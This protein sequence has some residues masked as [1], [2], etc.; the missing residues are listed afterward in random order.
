MKNVRAAIQTA[1]VLFLIAGLLTPAT[2]WAQDE[3]SENARAQIGALLQ[4]KATWNATE[5]KMDSR[6]ILESKRRL[7]KSF[8]LGF[9]Q[10]RSRARVDDFDRALI[11]IDAT[12]TQD[13]LN[14]ITQLGGE[15][16][17]SVPRFD[18]IRAAVPFEFL[19]TLASHTDIQSIR[20][21]AQA[22]TNK[23]NTTEGDGAHRA[24]IARMNFG[25]DGTGVNIGV[26][27]DSVDDLLRL[28]G[29]GD[30]PPNV[31][32]LPGQA[33]P[34]GNTS[35]GTAM[36]E[37]IFDL[38]PGAN[39]FFATAFN[40]Q[41]SFADNIER[42]QAAGCQVIVDDVGYFAESV[43]QDDDVAQA[44]D[45]V[46]AAGSSYFSAIGN[47]GNFNDGQGGVYEN[48]FIGIPVDLDGVAVIA[49]VFGV[50][51]VT[52]PLTAGAPSVITLQWADPQGGSSNDYD[53]VLVD[54]GGNSVVDFSLNLQNGSQDPFEIIGGA[55]TGFQL[56][57]IRF[58]GADEDRYFHLN[59]NRGRLLN[60]TPG[61][62]SGHA[63]A[64]GA[65]G[66]AA[67]DVASAPGGAGNPFDG[68]EPV[69]TFSSDGPRRIFFDA[70][71]TPLT[72]GNFSSTGGVVRQ[73]PDFAAADGV[74][75]AT[76]VFFPFNP[77]FGTSAAAPHAA[78]LAALLIDAGVFTTP[79]QVRTAFE[80][81]A[82]DIEAPG[83]DRDSGHGIIDINAAL[84]IA[85]DIVLGP[86]SLAVTADGVVGGVLS[87]STEE[88]CPWSAV[89]N[90]PFISI[91]SASL[92]TGNG[93][94]SYTVAPNNGVGRTG[95]ISVGTEIF[96]V[97][98]QA[99]AIP[100]SVVDPVSQAGCIGGSVIFTA[101]GSG[102]GP[103]GQQWQVNEGQ[104]FKNIDGGTGSSLM[105][106]NINQA[107]DGFQYHAVFFNQC[108]NMATVPAVL[109]VGQP[110]TPGSVS[111][112][113][114]TFADRV[115]VQWSAVPGAISYRVF[116]SEASGGGAPVDISGSIA[117]LQFDD[118]TA[119]T[120]TTTGC[121]PREVGIAYRYFIIATNPCGDGPASTTATGAVAD[122]TKISASLRPSNIGDFALM[123]LTLAGIYAF[124]RRRKVVARIAA[125]R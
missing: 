44:V 42:L 53:L 12:V 69:E 46:T 91:T 99:C 24:D 118:L 68:S 101:L 74:M 9:P 71:G 65:F 105:V 16:I 104:G 100:D 3:L 30:L 80:N 109:T 31:T 58:S 79:D 117:T 98:Q 34:P 27:S 48:D 88:S 64:V 5:Q 35:E 83:V 108:G 77:F 22:F 8:V 93:A 110:G 97:N 25:V 2:A 73:K 41:A 115:R 92:G 11:D 19:E 123:L 102:T 15:V 75:T 87:I 54:P 21:A 125:N 14:A 6:L 107:M 85:C 94:I 72:P 103:L 106:N 49:H 121:S 39:L 55:P 28:Q 47:S 29:L 57:V 112:S 60:S 38:A 119:T 82:I 78:A 40:G 32:V 95:T 4:E 51:R 36:L 26:L 90:S 20:Q 67:V 50:N 56:A 122:P 66:I 124:Q 43:F 81:T 111:A 17:V 10:P 113:N 70:S 120:E 33:G 114:G 45:T 23:V 62:A 84:N 7:G 86:P 89:S 63:A 61:Q 18:S 76:D 116:R 37:I 59:T 1:L 13:V 96:P 52:N